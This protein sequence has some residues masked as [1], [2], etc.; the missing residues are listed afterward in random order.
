MNQNMQREPVIYAL[1]DNLGR[2]G[3]VG[4]TKVNPKTRWWEHRSRAKNNH[5]A[6]VYEWMRSVGI[7]NVKIEVLERIGFDDDAHLIEVRH[8]DRLLAE[9]HP[10][11]NQIGRD[12]VP[13]SNASRMRQILSEKRKGRPT[14]IKGRRGVD[15]GWTEERKRQQAET[16]RRRYAS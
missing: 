4:S 15:A 2:Y 14:W 7:D 12:G 10:I 6:P 9:G 3:Y 8:I 5:P 11:Q 13:Y 16:M 1:L